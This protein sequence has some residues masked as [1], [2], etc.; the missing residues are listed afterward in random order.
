MLYELKSHLYKRGI[1]KFEHL[2]VY[3]DSIETCKVCN[4]WYM[5]VVAEH[6]LIE[7]EKLYAISQSIPID[8]KSKIIS[9][10]S[11]KDENKI[12]SDNFKNKLQQWRIMFY[13]K[14]FFD[15]NLDELKA[16]C[17]GTA[18]IIDFEEIGTNFIV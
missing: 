2:E 1:F 16:A 11:L 18:I 13:C 7:I 5:L 14:Q 3:K 17:K 6:E 10:L 9:K 4:I 8:D 15:L 12:S